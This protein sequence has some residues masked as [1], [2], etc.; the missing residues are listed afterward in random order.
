MKTILRPFIFILLFCCSSASGQG[1]VEYGIRFLPQATTFRY[2]QG[3]GPVIDFSKG[4]AP[5]DFRVR[6]AQGVGVVFNPLQRLRLGADLLYSLQ[7]GGY[8]AR[9][10]NLDYLKL[11]LWIGF[12]SASKRKISFTIQAGFEVGYLLNAKL[13]YEA[14][15]VTDIRSYVNRTSYGLS[16]AAGVKFRV[17]QNY[18]MTTQLYIYS[19]I[20]ALAS[21]NK[22]FGVYNY[23]YPGLRISLDGVFVPAKKNTP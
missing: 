9:K 11:P 15:T 5:Y 12:N 3:V 16:L 18:F 23:I 4:T 2:N 17:L 20:P 22:I 8:Y 21:T 13:K 14:G 10:T 19:D 7:G 1:Q 6:T